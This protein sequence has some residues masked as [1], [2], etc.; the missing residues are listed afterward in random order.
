MIKPAVE[1]EIDNAL[2]EKVRGYK[3]VS[4]ALKLLEADKYVEG[5]L[6]QANKVAIIRLGYNDHGPVHARITAYNGLKIM[7][8]LEMEPTV[9]AEDIGDRE[10][11]MVAVLLGSFLHDCGI[12]IVREGH[13]LAGT[14]VSRDPINKILG[15]VYKDDYKVA[16]MASIISEC[17]LCHMGTYKAT[18]LE[19]RVV[20]T[21]DGT[22]ASKGRARVP[23]HIAKPDIH[24]FSALAIERVNIVK[25][26]K[27]PV[28][29]EVIM[30][31]PAGVFQ[32]EAIMKKKI[33]D[34][35]ME[36]NVEILAKIKDQRPIF[37]L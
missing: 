25:G 3:K 34:A 35:E 5:L 1:T 18:S 15:K 33:L 32:A 19:A 27:K 11:S 14:V 36:N 30:D 37:I 6:S 9:V 24:K 2:Q 26:E 23:F 4:Y 7:E 10:D 29:F 22:D 20:E 28:R 16:K 21:A 17:I 12:S 8:L 31:N 13:E